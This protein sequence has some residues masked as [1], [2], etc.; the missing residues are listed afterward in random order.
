MNKIISENIN[1]I[2]KNK[3]LSQQELADRSGISRQSINL[4]LSFNKTSNPKVSSLISIAHAL[5]TDFPQLFSRNI[6]LD[7]PFKK[8]MTAEEYNNILIQNLKNEL[9]GRNQKSISIDPG[10]SESTI[11][12]LLNKNK[13]D[14]RLSTLELIAEQIDKPISQLFKRGN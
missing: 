1:L 9:S 11:S 4:I 7:K 14:I 13:K 3:N 6:D 2:L 12:D 10:L 5:D 8:I